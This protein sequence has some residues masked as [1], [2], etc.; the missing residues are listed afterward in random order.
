VPAELQ[1]SAWTPGGVIMG[2]EHRARPVFGA[3]LHPEPV[4]ARRGPPRAL[5]P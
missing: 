3:Q 2:L 4:S 5:R 1:V